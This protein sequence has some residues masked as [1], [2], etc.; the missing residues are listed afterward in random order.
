M[1][2]GEI[3][4]HF[5]KAGSSTFATVDEEGYPATRIAQ[6]FAFDGEGLYFRTMRVKPFYRHLKES[7]RVSACGLVTASTAVTFDEDGMPV[8][9]PGYFIRVTGD[10]REISFEELSR[11]A[12]EEPMFAVGVKDTLRYPDM[13]TFCLSRFRG[14]I[15]DYDYEM[16]HRD[17]KLQRTF[18]GFGG[19]ERPF[20]GLRIG[21][22]CTG[23][24]VCMANC[25]FKAISAG[26]DGKCR[27]DPG[28]C[29]A[30]GTCFENCPAGAIEVFR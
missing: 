1:E 2:I 24:G 20:R 10:C 15:Y 26:E 25:T 5:E 29:D 28:R 21:D 17:H 11:K 3:Y 8:D 13:A 9:E 7:G 6:F 30:C 27:I 16:T 12:G 22:G 18:F 4:G 19:F 23:C 14:E